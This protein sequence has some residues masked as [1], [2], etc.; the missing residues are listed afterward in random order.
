MKYAILGP[1]GR[2]FR[3]LDQPKENTVEITNAKAALVEANADKLGYFIIDG[4][5]VTGEEAIKILAEKRFQATATPEQ[6]M[7][8]AAYN[9]AATVFESMSL[10][11]QALWE[12]VR[13]KVAEAIKAGDFAKAK[14]II[15]TVPVLYDG[16]E[17]D[18]AKFLALFA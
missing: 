8:R 3:V 10:G 13:L 11:K 16:I 18:R 14:N 7:A 6:K 1:Q 4:T 12:V 9:A 2:I 5:F 17:V 15:E